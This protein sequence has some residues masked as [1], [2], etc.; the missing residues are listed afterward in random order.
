MC[1]IHPTWSMVGA[2]E[3][4]SPLTSVTRVSFPCW[5]APYSKGFSPSSPIFL[6]PQKK[7]T[8]LNSNSIWRSNKVTSLLAHG[9]S[10]L[11]CLNK[12]FIIIF[13]LKTQ[14]YSPNGRY[15]LHLTLRGCLC[16]F[17]ITVV[18]FWAFLNELLWFGYPPPPQSL[19]SKNGV[20]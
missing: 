8:L 14:K 1:E 4:S 5:L 13:L 16:F 3:M 10:L 15:K 19:F 7:P 18:I 2:V 11:P 6:P 17:C 9:Y 20:T 12:V